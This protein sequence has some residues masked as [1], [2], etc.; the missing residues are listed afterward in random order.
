MNK[1]CQISMR[2]ARANTC[3]VFVFP[4]QKMG[5]CSSLLCDGF[6]SCSSLANCCSGLC[7]DQYWMTQFSLTK[8][9]HSDTKL[10]GLAAG[11]YGVWSILAPV[12]WTFGLALTSLSLFAQVICNMLGMVGTRLFWRQF[13]HWAHRDEKE[14]RTMPCC[15][16]KYTASGILIMFFMS[17]LTM[18]LLVYFG[19]QISGNVAT[20]WA[21][22]Y[23][24]GLVVELAEIFT[25]RAF[26][27]CLWPMTAV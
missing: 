23:F 12:A 19:L 17:V 4:V 15:D 1:H 8:A 24:P 16:L 13:F 21:A 22:S 27:K 5:L 14:Y 2:L 10:P 20:N 26:K 3:L 9:F 7:R 25:V 18:F 11:F 6:C